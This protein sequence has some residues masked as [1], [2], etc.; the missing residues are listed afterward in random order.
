M[1]C[2][3]CGQRYDPF[4]QENKFCVT[5][6]FCSV[7]CLNE[8]NARLVE[9]NGIIAKAEIQLSD[10]NKLRLDVSGTTGQALGS[11]IHFG[12]KDN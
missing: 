6:S 9:G 8:D 11:L 10:L 5:E 7:E 12:R 3:N 4:T 1:I 2:F